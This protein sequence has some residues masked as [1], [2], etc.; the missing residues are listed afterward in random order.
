[1]QLYVIYK[2]AKQ[3]IRLLEFLQEIT[4]EVTT[5]ALFFL[6]KNSSK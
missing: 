2:K 5:S 3:S 6:L 4:V 1:M